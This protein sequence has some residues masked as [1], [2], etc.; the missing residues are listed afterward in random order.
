MEATSSKANQALLDGLVGSLC[1][2][3]LEESKGNECPNTRIRFREHYTEILAKLDGATAPFRKGDMVRL[4][5]GARPGPR[6]DPLKLGQAYKVFMVEYDGSGI[7][8]LTLEEMKD[9]EDQI[10]FGH[11]QFEK[12]ALVA[13]D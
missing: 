10:R 4:R 8:L 7:W 6:M 12:V 13:I 11:H 1:T 5:E 3:K 9:R 2:I